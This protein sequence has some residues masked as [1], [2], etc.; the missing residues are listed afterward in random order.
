M[1]SGEKKMILVLIIITVIVIGIWIKGISKKEYTPQEEINVNEFVQT[2]ED[3]TKQSTSTKLNETKKI[4]DFEISN[5]QIIETNGTATITATVTNTSNS[6][7]KEFPITIKTLRKNG[8]VIENVGAYVGTTK[9]GESRGIN[10][11]I[12]MNIDEIYDISIEI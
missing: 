9:A 10:A 6:T 12:N 8:E 1:K 3:G 7:Q 5:I 11:S 2:F 4:G